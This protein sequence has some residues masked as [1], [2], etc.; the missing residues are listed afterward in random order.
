MKE[1]SEHAVRKNSDWS[2]NESPSQRKSLFKTSVDTEE[3][4]K[5]IKRIQ[6]ARQRLLLTNPNEA[7][8][9]EDFTQHNASTI[10]SGLSTGS[11][12]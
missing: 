3:R 5:E 8:L 9:D 11:Q 2:R 10:K 1:Q 6:I 4:K 7:L 12:T